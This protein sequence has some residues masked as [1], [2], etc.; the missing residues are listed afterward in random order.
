M[1]TGDVRADLAQGHG[2]QVQS[3]EADGLV[4]RHE[5]TSALVEL[6]QILLRADGGR[7]KDRALL[8]AAQRLVVVRR[9]GRDGAVIHAVEVGRGRGDLGQNIALH[10]L[11]HH[12]RNELGEQHRA[13]GRVEE[14]LHHVAA[15]ALDVDIKSLELTLE[16]VQPLHRRAAVVF[17]RVQAFEHS[18]KALAALGIHALFEL[19]I[20]I[21]VRHF[22]PPLKA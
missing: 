10:A 13:V 15:R 14:L 4:A 8:H 21:A 18:G 6:H 2:K 16:G 1:H 11:T 3:L 7:R 19:Q 22:S 17:A 20:F 5:H 9:H 12:A